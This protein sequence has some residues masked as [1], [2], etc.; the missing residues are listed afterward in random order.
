MTPFIRN[1]IL[2]YCIGGAAAVGFL[3]IRSLT[4]NFTAIRS[5]NRIS[6]VVFS[7]LEPARITPSNDL[8]R[9][10]Y[11]DAIVVAVDHSYGLHTREL[12]PLYQDPANPKRLKTAGLLQM[13]LFPATMLGLLLVLSAVA[14]GAIWLANGHR[15]WG[16]E[17]GPSQWMF[18]KPPG[19]LPGNIVL[20][21]PSLY[22][23]LAVF[24]SLFGVAM[25]IAPLFNFK[26]EGNTINHMGNVFYCLVGIAFAMS[27]W[28]VAV[29]DVSLEVSANDYG[30][31]MSSITGWRDVPWEMI[32]GVENQTLLT[33]IPFG[34]RLPH[35][36]DPGSTLSATAFT[37]ARGKTLISFGIDVGAG[38][39][40]AKLFQ[41]CKERTGVSLRSTEKPFSF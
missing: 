29:R 8:D 36:T 11:E 37:D 4:E 3:L 13:W 41:L 16:P 38:E 40:R 28:C 1:Y 9:A 6:G 17:Q 12:T 19:P 33:R 7:T 27:G 21:S 14:S 25:A 31:R 15:I 5:W 30:I 34:S 2:L 24:W 32:H 26:D 39:P 35:V 10:N 23:K 18:T 22:W 20:R